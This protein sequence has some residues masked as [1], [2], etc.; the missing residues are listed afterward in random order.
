MVAVLCMPVHKYRLTGLGQVSEVLLK[1][2]FEFQL[3]VGIPAHTVV[4]IP[5][6]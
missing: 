1:R 2:V 3:I 5:S 4:D 6:V